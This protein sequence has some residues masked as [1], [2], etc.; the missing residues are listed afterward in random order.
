MSKEEMGRKE[1][2][3]QHQPDP[4]GFVFISVALF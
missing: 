1:V 2:K 3:G 4:A